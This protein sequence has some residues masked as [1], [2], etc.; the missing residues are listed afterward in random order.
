MDVEL[1]GC[2]LSG[3]QRH[4]LRRRQIAS[5]DGGGDFVSAG[6]QAEGEVRPYRAR[7][8]RLVA[9]EPVDTVENSLFGSCRGSGDD[10]RSLERCESKYHRPLDD[11]ANA[12][13]DPLANVCGAGARAD[14]IRSGRQRETR[15][16][17]PRKRN[18][19]PAEG[20]LG[21]IFEDRIEDVFDRLT[22]VA[23]CCRD[24]EAPRAEPDADRLVIA[25]SEPK[26]LR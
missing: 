26:R 9:V 1:H 21:I 12:D 20:A 22:R 7:H 11:F 3:F 15:I 5:R 24:L 4:L 25:R 13:R 6:W 2:G 23:G 10:R 8:S 19:A 14:V 16:R 18:L 17:S